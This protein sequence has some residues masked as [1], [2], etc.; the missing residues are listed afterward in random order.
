MQ[1]PHVMG[2][3]QNLKYLMRVPYIRDFRIFGALYIGGA[4]FEKLPHYFGSRCLQAG[5]NR[6]S[7]A[8]A[9]EFFFGG[10]QHL[11]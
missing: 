2:G 5:R 1:K 7:V 4:L 3:F 8:L 10:L 11:L 6:S 9:F